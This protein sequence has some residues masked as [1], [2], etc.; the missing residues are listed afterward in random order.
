MALPILDEARPSGTLG[1]VPRVAPVVTQTGGS[2]GPPG[3]IVH[4]FDRT[5][6]GQLATGFTML[7]LT[8]FEEGCLPR[9]LWQITLRREDMPHHSFP[10]DGRRATDVSGAVPAAP[11]CITKARS[12]QAPA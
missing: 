3:F 2:P 1:W 9:R 4:F 5:L 12:A 7:D 11:F 10:A 8:S 6:I